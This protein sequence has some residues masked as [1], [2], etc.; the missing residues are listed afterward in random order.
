MA[1]RAV[2][3]AKNTLKTS[4]NESDVFLALLEYRPNP[5]K[6]TGLAPSSY[7]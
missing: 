1:E 7:E 3:I 4:N 2:Q 6:G 5:A